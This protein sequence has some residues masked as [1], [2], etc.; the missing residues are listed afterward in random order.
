MSTEY[1]YDKSG[2]TTKSIETHA[3]GSQTTTEYEYYD[4]Y[5]SLAKEV[6][7]YPGGSKFT[8]EYIRNAKGST[9]KEIRTKTESDGTQII[10]EYDEHQNL[11]SETKIENT[12]RK[13]AEV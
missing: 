4:K 11:I 7:T 3:D 1:E 2:N 10:W 12:N 8:Q 9:I 13:N 6:T 5:G